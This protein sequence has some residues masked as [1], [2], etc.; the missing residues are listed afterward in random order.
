MHARAPHP[1]AHMYAA[2]VCLMHALDRMIRALTLDMLPAHRIVAITALHPP[3]WVLGVDATVH[4]VV[5]PIQ[6]AHLLHR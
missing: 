1:G 2:Q 6:C 4:T 5:L 3:A